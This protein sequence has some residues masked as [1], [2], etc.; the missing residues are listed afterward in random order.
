MW[1]ENLCFHLINKHGNHISYSNSLQNV[2]NK[3]I[4][5]RGPYAKAKSK[6]R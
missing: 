1:K 4:N 6:L 5:L 3:A 2:R